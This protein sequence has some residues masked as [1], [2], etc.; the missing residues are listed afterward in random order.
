MYVDASSCMENRSI[1]Q[2]L[3]KLTRELEYQVYNF[4]KKE[5]LTVS[6][7]PCSSESKL[8]HLGLLKDTNTSFYHLTLPQSERHGNVDSISVSF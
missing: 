8:Q 1:Q 3:H 7:V 6:V 2:V 4:F 5:S